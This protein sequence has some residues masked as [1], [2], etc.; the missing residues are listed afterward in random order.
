MKTYKITKQFPTYSK[1]SGMTYKSYV[2]KNGIPTLEEAILEAKAKF[3]NLKG[4]FKPEG[5]KYVA[6][7]LSLLSRTYVYITPVKK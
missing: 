2:V 4:E 6:S 7:Y 1:R 3:P 5:S